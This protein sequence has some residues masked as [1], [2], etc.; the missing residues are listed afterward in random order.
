MSIL[1]FSESCGLHYVDNGDYRN[2]FTKI[3]KKFFPP[4]KFS[5]NGFY[6]GNISDI[7]CLQ[8]APDGSKIPLSKQEKDDIENAVKRRVEAFYSSIV[9][10]RESNK[11]VLEQTVQRDVVYHHTKI[12]LAQT[13]IKR[14][15][16]INF[17]VD[18]TPFDNK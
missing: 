4:S 1:S 2:S 13:E 15:S 12:S 18:L 9:N 17:D 3:C 7:T 8:Q 5:E 10:N 11:T 6:V 16:L 14:P